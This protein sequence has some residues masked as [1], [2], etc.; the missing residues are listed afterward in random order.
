MNMINLLM[1]NRKNLEMLE[2]MK[3][4]KNLI[5][6]SLMNSFFQN[7]LKYARVSSSKGKKVENV[8]YTKV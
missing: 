3:M 6:L 2:K 7:T 5:N 8:N 4:M 1:K